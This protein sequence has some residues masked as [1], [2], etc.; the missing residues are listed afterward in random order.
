MAKNTLMQATLSH[1]QLVYV[2]TV[3]I[4]IIESCNVLHDMWD[5][6][7]LSL[8]P[9]LTKFCIDKD[10]QSIPVKVVS[11]KHIICHKRPLTI[12]TQMQLVYM[13]GVFFTQ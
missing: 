4:Q 1:A 8:I 11:H 7:A 12:D 13:F 3:F 6:C 2:S 9:A 10:A 5:K